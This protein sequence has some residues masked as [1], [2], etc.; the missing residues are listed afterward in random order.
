MNNAELI[1][2]LRCCAMYDCEHCP[3]DAKPIC[4]STT[5]MSKAAADALEA[6]EQRIKELESQAAFFDAEKMNYQENIE[7]RNERIK[8]LE[9]RIP[10]EGEWMTNIRWDYQPQTVATNVGTTFLCMSIGKS[11]PNATEYGYCKHSV[12]NNPAARE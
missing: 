9:A 5:E 12:C 6:A 1:K 4:P 8:E 11:C 3:Y 2:A 10:K 7:Y